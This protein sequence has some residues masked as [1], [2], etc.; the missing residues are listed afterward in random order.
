[1][2]ADEQEDSSGETLSELMVRLSRRAVAELTRVADDPEHPWHAKHGR[3]A[4]RTLAQ[5]GLR[6]Y[7][8]VRKG[9]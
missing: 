6:P 5:H 2:I 9:G 1:V 8:A 3:D 4:A 7:A